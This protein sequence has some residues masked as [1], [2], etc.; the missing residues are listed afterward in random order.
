[1]SDES[2]QRHMQAYMPTAEQIA[3]ELA[4]V[5]STDGFFGKEGLFV[6]LLT[7][8]LCCPLLAGKTDSTAT[9]TEP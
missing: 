6:R 8:A 5:Q 2:G 7:H 9:L 4:G 3:E 1:M